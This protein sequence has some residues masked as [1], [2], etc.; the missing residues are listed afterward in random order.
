MIGDALSS[1]AAREHV[2]DFTGVFK[3]VPLET[4]IEQ[5]VRGIERRARRTVVPRQHRPTTLVPG[6]VQALVERLAFR[7]RT[8][9]RALELGSIA[10]PAPPSILLPRRPGEPGT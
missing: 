4:V 5:L 1:P 9:A 7:P 2:N 6:L 10:E 8:I 3:T